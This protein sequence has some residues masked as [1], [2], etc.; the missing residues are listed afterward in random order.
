MDQVT[1]NPLEERSR[2]LF[3]DVTCRLQVAALPW[4]RRESGIEIMLITSRDT[5]RWVLPKGWLEKGEYLWEAAAREA[6]E[7]A[8]LDGTIARQ[9]SGRYFY[10]KTRAKGEDVPCEVLIYA[11]EVKKVA[12]KWKERGERTRR[13]V[14][15]ALAAEMVAEPELGEVIATFDA[16]AAEAAE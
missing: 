8:G 2:R 3:G 1:A 7:E 4:R 11:L 15:P 12:D 14:S 10:A 9:E 5:G 6:K 16:P 13:W